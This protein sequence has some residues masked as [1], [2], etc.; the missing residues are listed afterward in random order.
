M[1]AFLCRL[2]APLAFMTLTAACAASPPT[3]APPGRLSLPTAA[4]A[5]CRLPTLPETPTQA[6]LERV[7]VER[8]AALVECDGARRLAVEAL[9]AERL[10]ADP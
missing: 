2:I 8:G 9:R 6:D 3:P 10:L 5:S 7:Y 4:T 1:P